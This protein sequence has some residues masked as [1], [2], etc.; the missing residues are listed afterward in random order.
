MY[1][2]YNFSNTNISN[3][4]KIILILRGHIRD[5]FK[6]INLY[7]LIKSIYIKYPN[8][9]IY[10]HTW[11]IYNNNLSW[12]IIEPNY[13]IV[14]INI[15]LEYFNDIKNIIK[16][17]IIE[18]DSQIKLIGNLNGKIAPYCAHPIKGWKN[19][20]Y[21]QFK[22]FIDINDIIINMR[23]DVLYNSNSIE[24]ETIY[25]FINDNINI[26]NDKLY[27]NIFLFDKETLGID[28]IYI[29]N[30][31]T[32]TKLVNKFYYELDNIIIN[33]LDIRSAEFLVFYI[34]N[35]L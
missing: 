25:N 2:I 3:N 14:N 28:N 31:N 4:K 19:Y 17:I 12:R 22:I 15:I 34:N 29:G 13:N 9:E 6:T 26:I 10:I 21:S 27:K 16:H 8:L 18:D 1:M 32:M 33:Y 20:W 24:K 35:I 11:N 23:F 30:I 5:S 7:N